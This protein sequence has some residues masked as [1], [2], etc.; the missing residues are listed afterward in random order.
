MKLPARAV[1]A[2]R[3]IEVVEIDHRGPDHGFEY[4]GKVVAQWIGDEVTDFLAFIQTL[5][6]SKQYRC[7][8]PRWSI[9]VYE[10]CLDLLFEAAF[11]FQCHEVRMY[12]PAVPPELAYQYFKPGSGPGRALLDR[13]RALAPKPV[14]GR[15]DAEPTSTR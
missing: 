5:P 14:E 12:G 7:F 13:F 15:D 11:C 9:R 1:A 2:A 10:D 8:L 4:P 6:G 3:L